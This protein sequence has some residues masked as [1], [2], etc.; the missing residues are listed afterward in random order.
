MVS[1]VERSP[2]AA[3]WWTVARLLLVALLALMLGGI[4]LSLAASPPVASRLGLEPFYFVN[5]HVLYLVPALVVMLATSFLPFR[6]I[7]RIALVV[8]I[9]SVLLVFATLAFGAEVKGARRWIVILGVNLQPS[10]FLKPAFVILVAWLFGET[11]RRPEMR[12]TPWRWRCCWWRWPAWC[13]SPTSAR[14]C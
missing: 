1:R 5:R 13:C 8:F 9:V 4:V 14:P 6:Y 11:A 7:R 12:P 2:F 10:E 3:W